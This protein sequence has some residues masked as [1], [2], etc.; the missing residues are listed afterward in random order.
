MVETF[1]SHVKNIYSNTVELFITSL[2]GLN[3][4]RR[5]KRVLF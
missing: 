3:I 1:V 4:Q 2:N 5:Y